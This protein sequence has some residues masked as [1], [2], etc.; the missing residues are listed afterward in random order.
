MFYWWVKISTIHIQIEY[1]NL[2][3]IKNFKKI[4][5]YKLKVPILKTL[6]SNILKVVKVL[7]VKVIIGYKQY[8]NNNN[9]YY[10][11]YY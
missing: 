5:K 9:Y 10:Y 11:Y 8:Y 3:T 6:L 1:I 4:L 7:Q 2:I